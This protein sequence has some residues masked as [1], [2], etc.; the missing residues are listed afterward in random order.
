MRAISNNPLTHASVP[1]PST[2]TVRAAP[3]IL[4]W[5]VNQRVRGLAKTLKKRKL[6]SRVLLFAI[7]WT[8]QFMEF[9][10]PEYWSG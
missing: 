2:L 1:C 9:S 4:E 7:P 6:L 5:W 8:I 3:C 10:R